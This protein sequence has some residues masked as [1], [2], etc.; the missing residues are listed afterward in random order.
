MPRPIRTPDSHRLHGRIGKGARAELFHVVGQNEL[1]RQLFAVGK[2][3]VGKRGYMID[4]YLGELVAPLE[5][6]RTERRHRFGQLDL[7][8]RAAEVEREPLDALDAVRYLYLFQAELTAERALADSFDAPVVGYDARR[9]S[10]YDSTRFS[11][12]KAVVLGVV[13]GVVFVDG[14]LAQTV[15]VVERLFL[16][17]YFDDRSWDMYALE[18]VAG[19]ERP[20]S[21]LLDAFVEYDFA[22]VLAVVERLLADELDR[23]RDDDGFAPFALETFKSEL[24]HIVGYGDVV[25]SA[26]CR[27][28]SEK[29]AVFDRAVKFVFG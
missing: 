15:A 24:C 18:R 11:L 29:N 3:A 28:V 12:D 6:A 25:A 13:N 23:R 9:T 10:G 20:R 5:R 4:V 7:G 14:D 8:K 22:Q 2:H 19:V 16:F 27:P 1:A 26:A 21:E 17:V